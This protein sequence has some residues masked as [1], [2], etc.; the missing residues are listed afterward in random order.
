M[1][2]DA[3]EREI[4]YLSILEVCVDLW[5]FN[6]QLPLII[7]HWYL[8]KIECVRHAIQSLFL[9]LSNG[10]ASQNVVNIRFRLISIKITIVCKFKAT[11]SY[12]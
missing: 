12:G 7:L 2:L 8:V 1:L 4:F 3:F 11:Y 5:S 10:L 6:K 9:H